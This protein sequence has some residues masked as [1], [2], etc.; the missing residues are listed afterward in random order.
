MLKLLQINDRYI[1]EN[2]G[3]SDAKITSYNMSTS[4]TSNWL[5]TD[6]K[7]NYAYERY[8]N[9]K[10]S[11]NPWLKVIYNAYWGGGANRNTSNIS[12]GAEFWLS[13]RCV[14]ASWSHAYFTL[15]CVSGSGSITASGGFNSD[16][17]DGSSCRGLRPVL[18]VAK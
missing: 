15:R 13:S 7:G 11:S 2:K 1:L 3:Y 6:Q 10:K 5:S 12:A 16:T 17:G 4:G 18:Q 8:N 9:D 14:E